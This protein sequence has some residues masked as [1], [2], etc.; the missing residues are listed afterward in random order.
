MY[1]VFVTF[2]CLIIISGCTDSEVKPRWQTLQ[3]MRGKD[4]YAEQLASLEYIYHKGGIDPNKSSTAHWDFWIYWVF[5]GKKYPPAHSSLMQVRD[6]MTARFLKE[7]NIMLA[8]DIF[9]INELL[10]QDDSSIK[11]YEKVKDDVD[12]FSKRNLFDEAIEA[13]HR[14]ER[15]DLIVDVI[16]DP[17]KEYEG[18]LA[19]QQRL[20]NDNENMRNIYVSQCVILRDTAKYLKR[21]EDAKWITQNAIRYGNTQKY[22]DALLDPRQDKDGVK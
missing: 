13:L 20:Q 22:K 6:N 3:E 1:Y 11:M 17:R 21:N 4:N 5:L 10:E 8:K 12:P 14:Q 19:R 18:I 15:Y 9:Y 16:K 7:K 2:A